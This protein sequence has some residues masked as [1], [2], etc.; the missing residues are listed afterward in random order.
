MYKYLPID[1]GLIK[2]ESMLEANLLLI[3]KSEA[4]RQLLKW[5]VL[6]ASTREC[7]EPK[8]FFAKHSI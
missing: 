3:H 5:A 1:A 8:G 7:I 6:C 2:D 4:T